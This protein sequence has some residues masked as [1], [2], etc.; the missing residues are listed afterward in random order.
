MQTPGSPN[1]FWALTDLPRPLVNTAPAIRSELTTIYRSFP[2]LHRLE[3]RESDKGPMSAEQTDRIVAELFKILGNLEGLQMS[4]WQKKLG[5]AALAIKVYPEAKRYL[6][7]HSKPR[8][9]W[10]PCLRYRSCCCTTST[11][12]TKSRMTP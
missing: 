2:P 6:L 1:L 5:V 10:T 8:S 4:D 3:C 12:T 11:N 7:A 9:N